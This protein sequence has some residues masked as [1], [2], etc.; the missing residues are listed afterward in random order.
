MTTGDHKDSDSGPSDDEK[1]AGGRRGDLTATGLD[2]VPADPDENLSAE[3]KAK[4]V[5]PEDLT[6]QN[7]EIEG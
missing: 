5:R 3:E 2:D 4:I 1:I 6:R 7:Y